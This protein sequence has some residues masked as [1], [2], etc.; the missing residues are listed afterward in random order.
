[1]DI[2]ISCDV[3]IILAVLLISVSHAFSQVYKSPVP[4][5]S[6]SFGPKP[7]KSRQQLKLDSLQALTRPGYARELQQAIHKSA[8]NGSVF[9]ITACEGGYLCTARSLPVSL[10]YFSGLR[11]NASEVRL[12]WETASEENNSGFEVERSIA[13]TGDYRVVARL[14]GSGNSVKVKKYVIVDPNTDGNTSYYR[15]KQIDLDGSYTYS[16]VIGVQGFKELLSVRALPNP[17]RQSELYFQLSGASTKTVDLAIYSLSG[18][19]VYRN[20]TYKP[21]SSERI[22]LKSLARLNT[23][24]YLIKIAAGED[25]VS[26]SFVVIN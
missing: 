23:G 22:A 11:L 21:E 7:F 4:F 6:S 16:T 14:D 26:A 2:R 1:M 5:R 8:Q 13:G 24:S 18:A 19:A 15:L 25:V 12:Q 3:R 17:A 20:K 9:R 10:V